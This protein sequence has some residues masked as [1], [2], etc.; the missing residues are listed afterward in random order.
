MNVRPY[1]G[2]GGIYSHK[3]RAFDNFEAKSVYKKCK[4]CTCVYLGPQN[5]NKNTSYPYNGRWESQSK[6]NLF[7]PFSVTV[8]LKIFKLTFLLAKRVSVKQL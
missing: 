3:S 2:S 1:Q 5:K 8:Y 6:K 7:Y 4:S